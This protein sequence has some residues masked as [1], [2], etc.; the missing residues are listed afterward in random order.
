MWIYAVSLVISVAVL[1]LYRKVCLSNEALIT[2]GEEL[3]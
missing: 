1:M 3:D 2:D